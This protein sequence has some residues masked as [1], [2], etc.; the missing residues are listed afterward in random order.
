MVAAAVERAEF[1]AT[2]ARISLRAGGK[3]ERSRDVTGDDSTGE[4]MQAPIGSG[5]GTGPVSME[6]ADA[7]GK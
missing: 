5:W 3:C 6:A 7:R 1:L 2:L 4:F